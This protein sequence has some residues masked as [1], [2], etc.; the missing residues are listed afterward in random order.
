[1]RARGVCCKVLSQLTRKTGIFGPPAKRH[2][3][4]V[5]LADRYSC[6][7]LDAGWNAYKNVHV[8]INDIRNHFERYVIILYLVSNGGTKVITFSPHFYW[9]YTCWRSTRGTCD[10]YWQSMFCLIKYHIFCLNMSL[11]TKLRHIYH[12]RLRTAGSPIRQHLHSKNIVDSPYCTCGAIEDT[13]HFLCVCHQFKDL[14]RSL[15]SSVSDI[16]HQ[17]LTFYS[18]VIYH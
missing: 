8:C 9:K 3:N 11:G 15:I 2:P 10:K 16:C 6:P 18:V 13:H 5:S 7:I 14:R 12:A 1:M 17:I 4:G